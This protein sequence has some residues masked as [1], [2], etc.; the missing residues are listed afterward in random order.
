MPVF[1]V[2]PMTQV[3]ESL[4]ASRRLSSTLLALFST[5]ALLI[6]A[7][8]VYGVISYDVTQRGREI[9]IR[10]ALGAQPG[11]I[12]GMIVRGGLRITAAGMLVG[13]AGAWALKRAISSQLFHVAATDPLTYFGMAALLAIVAVLACYI[14]ARRAIRVDPLGASRYE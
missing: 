3:I 12:L 5:L 11:S 8:G 13:L 6:A 2:R 9:A 14:P 1:N 4:S 7:V 10:M